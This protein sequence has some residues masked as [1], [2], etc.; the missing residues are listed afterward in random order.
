MCE[1]GSEGEDAR[2]NSEQSSDKDGEV[3]EVVDVNDDDT[4]VKLA[5]DREQIRRWQDNGWTEGMCVYVMVL[6]DSL[7]LLM[8]I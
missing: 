6:P 7:P 2:G 4:L 3:S 1:F 8:M 5:Q